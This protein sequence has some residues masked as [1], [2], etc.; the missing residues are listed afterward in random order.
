MNIVSTAFRC[1]LCTV[2]LVVNGCTTAPPG[3]GTDEPCPT[4]MD[5]ADSTNANVSSGSDNSGGVDGDHLPNNNADDAEPGTTG[6]AGNSNVCS[7]DAECDDGLFCTGVETCGA[8]GSCL[9]GTMPCA[10]GLVCD[11]VADVC[12]D[13]NTNN[14]NTTPSET[15]SYSR[16]L[17]TFLGGNNQDT[18][19]DIFVDDAGNIYVTGGTE[20]S[21]FPVTSGSYDATFNSGTRN[22]DVFVA[23]FDS[24]GNRVWATFVGGPN[25]DRAYAI[26][27]DNQGFVYVAGRAGVGFPV[28]SGTV[29]TAF[30]GDVNPNNPIYGTQDGF[31][32]KLSPDGKTLVWS[33][34]FGGDDRS[35]VRDMDIDLAGNVYI[36]VTDVSRTNPHITSGAFQTSIAGD[37]DG[38]IAKLSADGASVVWASYLGGSN[39][40]VGTPSIRVDSADMVIVAGGS[41][42]TNMPTTAGSFQ[43]IHSTGSQWDF[44]VAKFA[45][46]GSS[47]VFGTF[48]GGTRNEYTETHCLGIDAQDNIIIAATTTSD[49]FPT[50]SGVFQTTFGGR[51][52]SPGGNGNY[53]GDGFVAKLSSD[54]SQL[55][56]STFI[57]G[58]EGEGI[59]GVGVDSEGFIFV[60]GATFSSD[61]P[62]TVGAMQAN[63]GGGGD[64]F[65]VVLSPDLTEQVYGSYWGGTNEDLGRSA[66][67]DSKG[68]LYVAG[69]SESNQ[70]S[71]QNA[72][73]SS[74]N[75]DVEGAFAKFSY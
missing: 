32:F 1:G 4:G 71:T 49:D 67:T 29:Q 42:S 65:A 33:T 21:N 75:G 44:H 19:R 70:L 3:A 12:N 28:T 10:A 51:Q 53:G 40:D 61:F 73:Q 13:E 7:S 35:F 30:G 69:H 31:I 27:V 38:V 74:L 47:L 14:D 68:Y 9:D 34:Y 39:Y 18:I 64:F 56:A 46:D 58:S 16:D 63:Y 45:V 8:N 36:V 54:G 48:L 2:L 66:I 23:K 37:V 5:C 17:A 25:Y 11:D 26:E 60:S 72:F 62:V 57:G 52:T 22:H 43:P 6:G 55:L 24:S 41:S 15:R 50:T 20:S 59:E